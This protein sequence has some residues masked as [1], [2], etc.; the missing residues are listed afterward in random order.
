GVLHTIDG[1][2]SW[3]DDKFNRGCKDYYRLQDMHPA[4]TF[5]VDRKTGWLFITSGLIAK[6]TDGGR[7]WCDLF[8]PATLWPDNGY[9]FPSQQ[10]GNIHFKDPKYGIG[11]DAEGFIYESKDGGATWHKEGTTIRF[12]S[13]VFL[14][15]NNGWALSKD[16]KLFRLRV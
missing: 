13:L 15:A 12:D 14:D 6:S 10:I 8:D 4:A 11:L 9:A 1:G 5:F 16:K 7:T 2:R 3:K